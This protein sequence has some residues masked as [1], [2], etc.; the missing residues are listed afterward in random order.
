[1]IREAAVLPAER[2]G[3]LNVQA[4]IAALIDEVIIRDC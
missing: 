2:L 4:F 1:M 3:Y